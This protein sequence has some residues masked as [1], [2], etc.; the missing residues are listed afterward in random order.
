MKK[1]F[2]K[3]AGWTGMTIVPLIVSLVAQIMIGVIVVLAAEFAVG[4]SGALSGMD[5][6]TIEQQ[7]L[8][9]AMGSVTTALLVYHVLALIGFGI[10]Y[11]FGCGRPK[12]QKTGEFFSVRVVLITIIIG[13]LMSVSANGF[14]C[15]AQYFLPDL[16][17]QYE[18]M[19]ES[20]GLGVDPLVIF[21]SVVIAP[22]GEE[23]LCRGLIFHYA[24]KV[25]EDMKNRRAAFW[26]ANTLQALMFGIMHGNLVQGFYAFVMGLGLGWLRRRY[27]SLY[28]SMLAHLAVN[29]SSTFILEYLFAPIP[30]TLPVCLL[31]MVVGI[32][33]IA[34][35]IIMENKRLAGQG[36]LL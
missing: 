7:A 6:E 13:L 27:K 25:V 15:A 10:W 19:M 20:I 2:W 9:A 31:I 16:I 22:V 12:P 1:G 18:E 3:R 4:F 23:L 5:M 35:L 24:G 17:N 32:A 14:L 30:G 33:G 36:A 8:D 29:F 34:L 11:Y 28:P 26:I 21:V